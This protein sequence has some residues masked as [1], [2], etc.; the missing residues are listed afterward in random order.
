MRKYYNMNKE[1]IK[2]VLINIRYKLS[3]EDIDKLINIDTIDEIK[4]ILSNTEYKKLFQ[5]E[6]NIETDIKKYFYRMYKNIFAKSSYNLSTAI[7]YIYL[8]EIQKNNIINILEG[9]IYN[10][11][12]EQIEEKITV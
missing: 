6:E 3:K 5:S 7:S 1:E 4:E 11:S 10:I 2:E 12:K 8:E 9:I